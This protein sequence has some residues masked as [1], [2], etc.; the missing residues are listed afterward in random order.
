MIFTPI[1]GYK[2]T[3]IAIDATNTLYFVDADRRWVAVDTA[4]S[5]NLPI[6]SSDGTT[7]GFFGATPVAQPAAMVQT[8]ATANGT[9]GAYTA[10][11]ESVAFTGIDNLQ[12]GTVYAQL[13]DV[14]ALRVAYENLRVFTEDLA[15]F[16]NSLVDKLQALGL[17]Q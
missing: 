11:D 9:L 17:V 10:D 16:T 2:P 1:A 6:T 15:Q 5:D 7:L 8:Y 14:N 12:A 4:L 3:R 13:T